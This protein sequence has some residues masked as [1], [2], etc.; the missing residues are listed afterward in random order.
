MSSGAAKPHPKVMEEFK[1]VTRESLLVIFFFL[2]HV[3]ENNQKIHDKL[4]SQVFEKRW[5]PETPN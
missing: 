1:Y 2:N 5:T 3:Q 4:M